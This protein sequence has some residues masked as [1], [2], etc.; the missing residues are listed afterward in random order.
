MQTS[1]TAGLDHISTTLQDVSDSRPFPMPV[2]FHVGDTI[3]INGTM[4]RIRKITKRDVIL[5]AVPRGKR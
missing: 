1:E 2:L 4:F 3:E 5:R